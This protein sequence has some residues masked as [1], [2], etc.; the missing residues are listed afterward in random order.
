MLSVQTNRAGRTDKGHGHGLAGEG[1]GKSGQRGRGAE[2]RG[3]ERGRAQSMCGDAGEG[4]RIGMA[5]G[6]GVGS[7]HTCLAAPYRS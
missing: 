3:A 7:V 5:P 2:G 4:G 6:C 1:Q